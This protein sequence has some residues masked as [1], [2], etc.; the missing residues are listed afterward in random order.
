MMTSLNCQT[1]EP[2]PAPEPRQK[3]PRG[4]PQKA[5]YSGR[6]ITESRPERKAIIALL[7]LWETES[8]NQGKESLSGLP[9]RLALLAQISPLL[10]ELSEGRK[11]SSGSYAPQHFLY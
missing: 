11:A 5:P 6:T 2:V 4:C 10:S 7:P 8:G 1:G 3:A 9:G